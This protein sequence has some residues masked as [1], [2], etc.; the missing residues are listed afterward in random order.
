[1]IEKLLLLSVNSHNLN[2]G[3]CQFLVFNGVLSL[4]EHPQKEEWQQGC[5]IGSVDWLQSYSSIQI[6][7]WF[8]FPLLVSKMALPPHV[9]TVTLSVNYQLIQVIS[10]HLLLST[11]RPVFQ[12]RPV[13][14]ILWTFKPRCPR[15]VLEWARYCQLCPCFSWSLQR[16]QGF[17]CMWH[18]T[19]TFSCLERQLYFTLLTW[20][21]SEMFYCWGY[22]EEFS[23]PQLFF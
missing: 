17:I 9:H 12:S 10:T 5:A 8:V 20:E 6:L 1:M 22:W 15:P 19:S 2:S 21:E 18:L 4:S 16:I 7:D 11:V 23:M 3:A 14:I 13:F